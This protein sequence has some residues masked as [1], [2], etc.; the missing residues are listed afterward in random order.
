MK[1]ALFLLLFTSLLFAQR[2][3]QP[4]GESQL[5]I[6]AEGVVWHATWDTALAEAKRSQLPI[7]FMAAACQSGQ[8]SGIF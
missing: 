2:S 3:K 7:L 5:K 8:V 1:S 6:G 4:L